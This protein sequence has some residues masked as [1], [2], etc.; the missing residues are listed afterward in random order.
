MNGAKLQRAGRAVLALHSDNGLKTT[1]VVDFTRIGDR[2]S[3]LQ[4]RII[5]GQLTT[6]SLKVEFSH[7]CTKW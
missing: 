6:A 2:R 3:H 5:F 7:A 1:V 4:E